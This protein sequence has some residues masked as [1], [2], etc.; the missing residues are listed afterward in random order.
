V[1]HPE[2]LE[3]LLQGPKA[4]NAW[5]QED[6][7]HIPDLRDAELTMSQ[8]QFG[9]GNGGP[10]DLSDADLQGMVLRHSTLTDAS[11]ARAN[12]VATD[13]VQS[14][15]DGAD[16]TGADLTDAVLDYSEL[17]GANFNGAILVGA[18][19]VNVT[20][21]TQDQIAQAHGDAST[22]LPA[23]L[24]PPESWFPALEG[25]LFED[26]DSHLDLSP[27]SNDPYEVLG[28]ER[29]ATFD[30]IRTSFRSLVKR[31]HPDLNPDD[32]VAQERFKRVSIAYRILGDPVKRD[33]YNRGEIDS[34][35]DV[36]PE[37]EAKKEFRRYAFKFYTAAAASLILAIGILGGAW[38]TFWMQ[39]GNSVPGSAQTAETPP[40]LI[41]RLTAQKPDAEPERKPSSVASAEPAV[42]SAQIEAVT[43][44]VQEGESLGEAGKQVGSAAAD[45][46][47]S[48]TSPATVTEKTGTEP[49]EI[50]PA[51]P[52]TAAAPE[53]A[54]ETPGTAPVVSAGNTVE[55]TSPGS[56]DTGAGA[57]E[58]ITVSSTNASAPAVPLHVAAN[59]LDTRPALGGRSMT[60]AGVVEGGAE[61]FASVGPVEAVEASQTLSSAKPESAEPAD[62][63]NNKLSTLIKDVK[64]LVASGPLSVPSYQPQWPSA[65]GA[66]L[67]SRANPATDGISEI[68]RDRTM[69]LLHDAYAP[70]T[71]T[72]ADSLQTP[73]GQTAASEPVELIFD[74]ADIEVELENF[75]EILINPDVTA[76]FLLQPA[77]EES[78]VDT[79]AVESKTADRR[80]PSPAAVT[81]TQY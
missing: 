13:I 23:H 43:T 38:Y 75:P 21:L 10:I 37:F 40:K 47:G 49:E 42:P 52:S 74:L 65:H 77:D 39:D 57:A 29:N 2:D 26:Y 72:E 51:E 17:T 33:R 61:Q 8:R 11:L 31:L 48:A 64:M 9:P 53:S 62:D 36:H 50:A 27:L 79:A 70:P 6:P 3:K 15:L 19:L 46:P 69:D 7:D 32:S 71:A 35:G 68:F 1:A 60:G 76:E 78:I 44:A 25:G 80:E 54:S 20:G 73:R 55:K 67:K 14:R 81:Q 18:S 12:L 24:L 4:W 45:T 30:E 34:N 59:E 66:V 22:A 28:V 16:L 58:Q 5:R 41:E 56:S 63:E